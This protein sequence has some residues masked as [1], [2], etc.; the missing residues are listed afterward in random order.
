MTHKVVP[1]V[2]GASRVTRATPED[3]APPHNHEEGDLNMDDDTDSASNEEQSKV[4]TERVAPKD[5][6][7]PER[8]LWKAIY[9]TNVALGFPNKGYRRTTSKDRLLQEI[10]LL[11]EWL[12]KLGNTSGLKFSWSFVNTRGGST[13]TS[14]VVYVG[15]IISNVT[16]KAVWLLPASSNTST[17]N[18]AKIAGINP[19]QTLTITRFAE[20]WQEFRDFALL[21]DRVQS[22]EYG[23]RVIANDAAREVGIDKGFNTANLINVADV[24]Y[25][26]SKVTLFDHGNDNI[27][28]NTLVLEAAR[29]SD[30]MSFV[31]SAVK[32]DTLYDLPQTIELYYSDNTE[33]EEFSPTTPPEVRF[34]TR[35]KPEHGI[36]VISRIGKSDDP[37]YFRRYYKR[38]DDLGEPVGD[39][40]F[41]GTYLTIPEDPYIAN[42]SPETLVCDLEEIKRETYRAYAFQAVMGF[43]KVG[44]Q[45]GMELP[46]PNPKLA[47]LMERRGAKL[48]KLAPDP[49]QTFPAPA[50]MQG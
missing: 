11:E 27:N 4:K 46:E 38:L 8:G 31:A 16:R 33:A 12:F 2:G 23:L 20:I 9:R 50:R 30:T 25:A 32:L 45:R 47:N 42:N 10:E 41:R 36:V 21:E 19:S 14:N 17:G 3:V 13:K 34:P 7:V 40:G 43:I 28:R 35:Y 1:P 5:V 26:N 22:N 49:V 15:S 24:I 48:P 29:R 6:I 37:D 18:A 44:R 39:L